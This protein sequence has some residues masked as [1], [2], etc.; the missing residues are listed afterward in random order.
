MPRNDYATIYII[1]NQ[2]NGKMYIGQTYRDMDE[3]WAQHKADYKKKR[4]AEK[5]LYKAIR[6]DGIDNFKC[7]LLEKC[8]KVISDE[9]EQYYIRLYNT[10]IGNEN[11]NGYNATLGGSGKP[12]VNREMIVKKYKEKQSMVE[13]AQYFGIHHETVS[14]ILS[15]AGVKTLSQE[16]VNANKYGIPV[17]MLSLDGEYIKSFKSAREAAKEFTDNIKKIDGI[18]V[19]ISAVCKG[20]R[21][22]AYGYRWMYESDYKKLI[23]PQ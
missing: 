17:V 5:P 2:L 13:V 1:T 8:E 22:S 20:K 7:D 3:R 10:Y 18:S 11:S 23:T 6:E 19:H 14:N 15:D 12:F 9:R 4:Y 16:D 21:K